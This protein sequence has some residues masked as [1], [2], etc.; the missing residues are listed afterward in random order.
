MKHSMLAGYHINNPF[1]KQQS[2][3]N[4]DQ[5]H[6]VQYYKGAWWVSFIV[7]H[8]IYKAD[9]AVSPVRPWPYWFMR[10]EKWY[11]CDSDSLVF[12]VSALWVW[13]CCYCYQ[14]QMTPQSGPSFSVLRRIKTYLCS[15]MTQEQLN[16]LMVLLFCSETGLKYDRLGCSQWI[17]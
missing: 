13:N 5:I 11:S 14:P 1:C 10:G 3:T 9:R 12:G 17:E 16:S 7:L 15:T 6:S 8:G 4:L 2:L